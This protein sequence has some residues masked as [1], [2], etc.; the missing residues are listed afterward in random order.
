LTQAALQPS[1]QQAARQA[2]PYKVGLG[3]YLLLAVMILGWSGNYIAG[4]I[5]LREFPALLLL[6]WRA[7]FAGA[8]IL[9]AYFWERA[10][11]GGR[12]TWSDA[13]M[14]VAIGL[15][16]IAGNQALFV[17]GLSHT[18]VAHAAIFANLTPLMVLALSRMR[19]L[20]K[21]TGRKLAGMAIALSGVTLLKVLEHATSGPAAG[22]LGD[23]LIFS[24]SFV[25]SLFTVFGKP[26]ARRHSA[27]TVNTFAYVTGAIALSPMLVW[28]SA[29]VRL[30]AISWGA[31]AAA[32][33]M[34]MFSSVVSYLIYYFALARMVP[35]RVSV[36]SYFQPPL[37]AALGVII[38][39]ESLTIPL[40]V[41]AVIIFIGVFLT[42]R[43][44]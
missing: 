3:L 12:W 25:F 21:I 23:A 31:W 42:E 14:L 38:L 18:S 10:H 15:F 1:A 6:S 20:E 40:I 36:F 33:Y 11:G 19:G 17:L 2:A 4:K 29:G 22:W 41:S 9:P 26:L 44:R 7:L 16:G 13:P 28:Q 8:F 43:G 37:A 5:A 32:A 34:A 24:G 39:G 35:S 30:G 27:I